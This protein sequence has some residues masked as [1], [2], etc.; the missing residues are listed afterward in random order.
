MKIFILILLFLNIIRLNII[1]LE[2]VY[3]KD[4]I[5]ALE[6]KHVRYSTDLPIKT[7]LS[8]EEY[9][10]KLLKLRNIFNSEFKQTKII[11]GVAQDDNFIISNFDRLLVYPGSS[12][13]VNIP[14]WAS[15][16]KPI[17]DSIYRAAEL[18]RVIW[19]EFKVKQFDNKKPIKIN[20]KSRSGWTNIDDSIYRKL[21]EFLKKRVIQTNSID[22]PHKLIITD[23]TGV[24]EKLELVKQLSSSDRSHFTE[25]MTMG[26]RKDNSDEVVN[27][28]AKTREYV[29]LDNNNNFT[30]VKIN[31]AIKRLKRIAIRTRTVFATNTYAHC[32][33]SGLSQNVN[34]CYKTM[35][36]WMHHLISV[37]LSQS[38]Y[39][40]HFDVNRFDG[41]RD[42]VIRDLFFDIFMENK[43]FKNRFENTPII[44]N[45]YVNNDTDSIDTKLRAKIIRVKD[46]ETGTISGSSF[47]T[48]NF[49]Y[50]KFSLMIIATLFEMK[51]DEL[52]I[53]EW[54]FTKSEK[55]KFDHFNIGDDNSTMANSNGIEQ[56]REFARKLEEVS[57]YKIE[58]TGYTIAGQVVSVNRVT[59]I[60]LPKSMCH[61]ALN[62]RAWNSILKPFQDWGWVIKKSIH[63]NYAKMI[64]IF[65]KHMDEK[66]RNWIN[67]AK[68]PDNLMAIGLD[69]K[70]D[71]N[72]LYW[73]EDIPKELVN[74]VYY[75]DLKANEFKS[76]I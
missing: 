64:D 59:N 26:Y 18:I 8:H 67:N 1:K 55:I 57:I 46:T 47:T 38:T 5:E 51:F 14:M 72:A 73:K 52:D 27:G 30:K 61:A 19:N 50:F 2:G 36:P 34:D 42:V 10:D 39:T 43:E 15:E 23:V 4:I 75:T 16:I 17:R 45:S 49:N 3:M 7:D 12:T 71:I 70:S 28:E 76:I 20:R 29:V 22:L 65:G 48:T 66:F 25:V 60:D 56:A 69:F 37:V 11:D 35:R 24:P 53:K 21:P 9:A 33:V 6:R 74:L 13:Q 63:P 40:I 32:E 58:I 68:E 54:L 41:A 44:V 62:P 31:P